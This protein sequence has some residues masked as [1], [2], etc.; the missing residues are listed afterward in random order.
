[1]DPPLEV[2]FSDLSGYLQDHVIMDQHQQKISLNV[3]LQVPPSTV[4]TTTQDG[5][6][7]PNTPEILNTIVNM[8]AGPFA[9]PATF[10]P[11]P[12]PSSV[13]STVAAT[14]PMTMEQMQ[15]TSPMDSTPSMYTAAQVNT[16]RQ[17][18]QL[19]DILRFDF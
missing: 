17:V 14:T 6:H 1:M 2:L 10:Y 3:H 19:D 18:L 13:T 5:S 12:A 9:S 4:T 8:T 15:M 11:A 16:S 7:T